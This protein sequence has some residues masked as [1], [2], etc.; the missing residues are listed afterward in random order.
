MSQ[1]LVEKRQQNLAVLFDQY[2]YK[3][4]VGHLFSKQKFSQFN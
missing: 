4:A 2:E 3:S 1:R